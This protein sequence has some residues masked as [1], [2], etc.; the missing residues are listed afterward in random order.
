M[1]EVK[2]LWCPDKQQMPKI[3]IQVHVPHAAMLSIRKDNVSYN[4]QAEM[5]ITEKNQ[6]KKKAKVLNIY[7]HTVCNST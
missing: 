3:F 1:L 2:C 7:I 4:G 6:E 5:F